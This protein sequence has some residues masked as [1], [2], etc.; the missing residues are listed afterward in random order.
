MGAVYATPGPLGAQG[1]RQLQLRRSDPGTWWEGQALLPRRG[2]RC[3]GA[4]TSHGRAGPDDAGPGPGK[5]DV[6]SPTPPRAARWL[7][8]ALASD[9]T[10]G[11]EGDLEEEFRDRCRTLG[12]GRARRWYAK[13]VVVSVVPLFRVRF[14]EVARG[15]DMRAAGLGV[16]AMAGWFLTTYALLLVLTPA[17]RAPLGDLHPGL[18]LGVWVLGGCRCGWLGRRDGLSTVLQARRRSRRLIRLLPPPRRDR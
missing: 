3:G 18:F 14:R 16:A 11:M 7:L 17:G 6:R 1:A 10:E 15:L 5:V 4:A 13:E 9:G 2:L 12:P 8:V